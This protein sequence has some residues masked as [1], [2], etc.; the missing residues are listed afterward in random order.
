MLCVNCSKLSYI[1]A[2]KKCIRCNSNVNINIAV[3]CDA[4]S[5]SDR[6]CA[7]CLKKTNL[8]KSQSKGCGCGKNR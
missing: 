6:L 4:C 5:N 1:Y 3:L 2:N 7:I 8:N